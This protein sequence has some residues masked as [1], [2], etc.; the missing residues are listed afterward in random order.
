MSGLEFLNAEDR[1]LDV[2][3]VINSASWMDGCHLLVLLYWRPI[4]MFQ[5]LL[6]LQQVKVR[7]RLI[8]MI[9]M[10]IHAA[11]SRYRDEFCSKLS[12]VIHICHWTLSRLESP[13]PVCRCCLPRTHGESGW[14]TWWIPL[15]Y[16]G[17]LLCP[18]SRGTQPRHL[19]IGCR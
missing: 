1:R 9:I 5:L 15:H 14:Q 12:K 17:T 6:A 7:F 13:I 4:P 11:F 8:F 2:F 18:S 3:P 19:L 10:T 16:Q